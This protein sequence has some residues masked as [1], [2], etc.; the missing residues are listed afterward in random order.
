[1]S[2]L[3]AAQGCHVGQN[4]MGVSLRWPTNDENSGSER[5]KNPVPYMAHYLGEKVHI[6]Q[7]EKL[8][9]FGATH[10]CTIDVFSGKIVAFC[11]TPVKNN[12]AIYEHVY[13]KLHHQD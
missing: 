9:M 4:H 3:L 11:S 13:I 1:M 7:D 5:Q 6:D 10:I 8:V 12:C 2:G